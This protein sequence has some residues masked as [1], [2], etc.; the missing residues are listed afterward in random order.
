MNVADV[1]VKDAVILN[2]G[3]RLTLLELDKRRAG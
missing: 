1:E 2:M 3:H